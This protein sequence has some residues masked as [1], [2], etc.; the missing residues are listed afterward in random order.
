MS[1]KS[2]FMLIFLCKDVYNLGTFNLHKCLQL[3]GRTPNCPNY[4]ISVQSSVFSA[5]T[6]RQ[7]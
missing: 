5:A 7:Q 4:H 6:G 3:K 2:T 1:K